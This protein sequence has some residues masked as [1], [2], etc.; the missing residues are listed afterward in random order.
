MTIGAE[1]TSVRFAEQAVDKGLPPLGSMNEPSYLYATRVAGGMR[2][3]EGRGRR[4]E[5]ASGR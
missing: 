1:V 4:E 5:G 2:V 3:T